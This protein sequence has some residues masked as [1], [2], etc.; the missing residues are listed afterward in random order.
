[1]EKKVVTA[2]D[3]LVHFPIVAPYRF[4]DQITIA[5]ENGLTG[6]CMF[7]PDAFFYKGHFPGNPVTPGSILQEAAAQ[8]VLAFGMYLLG[9]GI[10]RLSDAVDTILPQDAPALRNSSCFYLVQTDLTFKKIVLPGEKVVIRVEKVFFRLNK[11]KCRVLMQTE[12]GATV[13]HGIV[14]GITLMKNAAWKE[15][16]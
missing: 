14:S 15:E 5:G 8:A 7:P 3:I 12:E 9:N 6:L 2:E 4:L 10:E 1:M 16:L 13:L 11:L